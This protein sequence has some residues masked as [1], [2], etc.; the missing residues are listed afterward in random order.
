MLPIYLLFDLFFLVIS[1]VLSFVKLF[2]STIPSSIPLSPQ[3]IMLLLY[4]S[5]LPIFLLWVFLLS[6]ILMC[7]MVWSVLAEMVPVFLP[8][9][10][11]A[12]PSTFLLLQPIL[13][14]LRAV[15]LSPLLHVTECVHL[16]SWNISTLPNLWPLSSLTAITS[17][18]LRNSNRCTS[19]HTVTI[20]LIL[21][22]WSTTSSPS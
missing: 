13:S 4:L 11:F 5:P 1:L 10:I 7:I 16:N 18:W 6:W 21:I 2:S 12:A 19:Q 20:L 22:Q 15:S 9:A 8:S 17:L 3:Q 14:L